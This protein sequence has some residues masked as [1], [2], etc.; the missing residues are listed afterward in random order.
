[1][2]RGLN[3]PYS[4]FSREENDKVVPEE[5]SRRPLES[6][7]FE[8]MARR[9]F[10]DP[11]P[12][13]RGKWWTLR[14]WKDTFKDGK[15]GRS[16]ERIRLAPISTGVR[17]VQRLASEKLEPLNQSLESIGSATN[18]QLDTRIRGEAFARLY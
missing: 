18:L 3:S 6:E 9:R 13:R 4:L 10:Q 2:N 15:H 8:R 17:E 12:E 7:D 1:M 14:V 5:S 11:K 16:R